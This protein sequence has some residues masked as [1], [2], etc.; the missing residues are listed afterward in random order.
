MH[1]PRY[2][3]EDAIGLRIDSHDGVGDAL[4]V[5]QLA[6]AVLAEEDQVFVRSGGSEEG[7]YS[8]QAQ[9]EDHRANGPEES[10]VRLEATGEEKK[11]Q[12]R[13]D[14]MLRRQSFDL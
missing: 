3:R 1:C 9:R 13:R 12:G 2:R 10:R 11:C 7:G 14:E 5:Q 4:R 8:L 6:V